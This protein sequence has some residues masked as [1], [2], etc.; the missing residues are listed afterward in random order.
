LIERD[1][2]TV[3]YHADGK[4]DS[5][6]AHWKDLYHGDDT[7]PAQEVG[8]VERD[9]I[10]EQSYLEGRRDG[11]EQGRESILQMM[12][13]YVT[14]CPRCSVQL[15]RAQGDDLKRG[16]F[17]CCHDLPGKRIYWLYELIVHHGANERKQGRREA[18]KRW[19]EAL[20]AEEE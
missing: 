17:Y 2:D 4:S 12:P 1:G 13:G 18:D 3:T 5:T 20:A 19:R 6:P 14:A 7:A 15:Q 9:E 8:E 16:D 11:V 10:F